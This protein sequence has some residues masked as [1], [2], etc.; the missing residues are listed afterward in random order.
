MRLA[1]RL[2]FTP[3]FGLMTPG[4]PVPRRRRDPELAAVVVTE[5]EARVEAP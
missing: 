3:A 1:P 2:R 5:I 4:V